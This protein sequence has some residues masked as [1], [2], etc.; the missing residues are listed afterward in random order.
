MTYI[1]KESMITPSAPSVIVCRLVL[2]FGGMAG[3]PEIIVDGCGSTYEIARLMAFEKASH[4]LCRAIC[5]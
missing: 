5:R 2:N 4:E 3:Y 1:I